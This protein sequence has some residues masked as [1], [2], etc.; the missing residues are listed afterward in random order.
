MSALKNAHHFCE[1]SHCVSHFLK[2]YQSNSCTVQP[3]DKKSCSHR[4]IFFR[5]T[6]LQ[7]LSA[8]DEFGIE[9]LTKQ[10]TE[11]IQTF[12]LSSKFSLYLSQLYININSITVL[13][14]QYN[15]C[16]NC[17]ARI[18]KKIPSTLQE[19][20]SEKPVLFHILR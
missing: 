6:S 3:A 12:F 19:T 14:N 17:K 2:C 5:Q 18:S 15:N 11:A 10:G 8:Q 16:N 1:L 20:Q 9:V 4:K 7:I 13:S